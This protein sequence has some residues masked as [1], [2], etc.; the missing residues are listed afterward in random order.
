MI[1]VANT[2][3]YSFNFDWTLLNYRLNELVKDT[4]TFLI[5][6]YVYMYLKFYNV[7]IIM[8]I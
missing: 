6:P 3:Y 2:T 4:L 5:K 1:Y 8:C 7:H